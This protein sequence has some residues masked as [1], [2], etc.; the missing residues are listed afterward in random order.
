M[1]N[2]QKV[3]TSSLLIYLCLFLS[4]SSCL[5]LPFFSTRNE[6]KSMSPISFTAK[7]TCGKVQAAIHTL[8]QSPPLRIVCYCKDCRGYYQTLNHM[9]GAEGLPPAAVLDVSFA[10]EGNTDSKRTQRSLL[11]IFRIC[12]LLSLELGWS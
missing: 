11:I 8:Q 6:T 4:E 5:R 9:A 3:A 10:G 2:T 7:C 12:L 1:R